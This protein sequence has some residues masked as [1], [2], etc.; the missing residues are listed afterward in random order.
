MPRRLV[1]NV[2]DQG[3]LMTSTGD[4]LKQGL[5]IS[6]IKNEEPGKRDQGEEGI[7]IEGLNNL[8]KSWTS[9]LTRRLKTWIFVE[10]IETILLY[11]C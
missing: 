10:V 1:Y 9:N 5:Q 2:N 7:S 3:P 4:P 6:W 11:S 8:K